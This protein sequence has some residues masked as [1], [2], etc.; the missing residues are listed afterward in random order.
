MV[1]GMVGGSRKTMGEGEDDNVKLM[2]KG[3]CRYLWRFYGDYGERGRR[4]GWFWIW[5]SVKP[6]GSMVLWWCL[7]ENGA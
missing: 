2:E 1:E 7:S 6:E 4:G 3:I 5:W